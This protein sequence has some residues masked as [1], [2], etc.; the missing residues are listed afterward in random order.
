MECDHEIKSDIRE[1]VSLY[2]AI[3]VMNFLRLRAEKDKVEL[4][5]TFGFSFRSLLKSSDQV[6]HCI[7]QRGAHLVN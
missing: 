6:S 5:L 2:T 1:Q 7:L 3:S 4:L